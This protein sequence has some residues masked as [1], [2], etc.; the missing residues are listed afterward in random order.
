MSPRKENE[1]ELVYYIGVGD[2]KVVLEG[3]DL[4]IA[5]DLGSRCPLASVTDKR[6]S[7]NHLHSVR[8]TLVPA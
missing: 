1:E 7:M 6:C 4:D 2:I 3:R 5:V 8:D